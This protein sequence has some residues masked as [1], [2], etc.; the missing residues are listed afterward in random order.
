MRQEFFWI[1]MGVL[2]LFISYGCPLSL[3]LLSLMGVLYLS[4]CPLSLFISLGRPGSL[5]VGLSTSGNAANVCAAAEVARAR[6]LKVLGLTGKDGG[7][8]AEFCNLCIRVPAKRTL[9]VQ[10]LHLPMYHTLC[11]MIEDG[12]F[13]C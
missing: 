7:R 3:L 8:L 5:F 13:H 1:F 4:G 2:Y 10:E 9:E 6:G 11:L 12:F